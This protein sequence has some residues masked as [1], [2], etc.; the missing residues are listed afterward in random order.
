MRIKIILYSKQINVSNHEAEKF[1]NAYFA[2]FPEIKL[3][4]DKERYANIPLN[5]LRYSAS[6]IIHFKHVENSSFCSV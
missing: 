4:M 5:I 3:Y 6:T 1:L 2:K